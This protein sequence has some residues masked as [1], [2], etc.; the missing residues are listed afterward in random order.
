MIKDKKKTQ[1]NRPPEFQSKVVSPYSADLGETLKRILERHRVRTISKPIVKLSTVLASG[2]DAVPATKRRGVVCE[3]PSWSCEHRYIGETKRSLSTRLKE[4]HR[5]T[6]PRNIPKI[7]DKTELT[8]HPAQSGHAF[9]WDYAHVLHHVNSYH[10]R[11]FLESLHYYLKTNT[12]NDKS[13][14]FPAIY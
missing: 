1:Y 8:K 4:H 12:V 11:I 6:L 14:N 7:P 3:I 10:K 5:D 2:K 13:A 9:N